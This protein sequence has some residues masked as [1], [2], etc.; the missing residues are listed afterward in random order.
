MGKVSWKPG[1]MVYPAPA[2]L[3]TCG[4]TPEEWNL[5]TVAWTGTVC[6][7]PPMCYVSVRPERASYPLLERCMEFTLNLTTD[8]IVRATDWAGVRSARQYD[9]WKETGL[10]PLPGE[11]VASPT[12]AESPLSI[13]C[14]IKRI[15]RLGSHDMMLADVVN[16]R[17]DE[18][19][20]DPATGALSLAK[21]GLLV[22]AHG[23][24]YSLGELLGTFGFSVRKKPK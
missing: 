21:A 10:T 12:I 5:L 6:S 11:K 18:R 2:A 4:A 1:T 14:R 24:Y 23:G 17:A 19:F 7:D 15:E 8:S 20:I 16:L 13:E 22:Y 3:V 9:K